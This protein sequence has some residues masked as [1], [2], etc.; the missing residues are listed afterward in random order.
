MTMIAK[1]VLAGLAV[2]LVSFS[3]CHPSGKTAPPVQ[4]GSSGRAPGRAFEIHIYKD[5]DPTSTKCFADLPGA[6]LWI[7]QKHTVTWV[8]DD[9]QYTI[10][11]SKGTHASPFQRPDP[12]FPMK[13]LD[14]RSPFQIVSGPLKDN[15]PRAYFN[16]YVK[17]GDE[18]STTY[19]NQ[20]KDDDPGLY[21]KP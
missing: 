6:T 12:Q 16:Y 13:Q 5:P 9:V 20:D 11:F 1:V 10:D 3:T 19:C 17:M 8:S 14:P 21:V 2:V 4:P 18:S 15:V 7:G